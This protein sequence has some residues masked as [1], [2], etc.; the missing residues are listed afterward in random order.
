MASAYAK[1][2]F[3]VEE[4]RV[5]LLTNARK[6]VRHRHVHVAVHD[7]SSL[8]IARK[9]NALRVF[10]KRVRLLVQGVPLVFLKDMLD[11]SKMGGSVFL[12]LKKVV[13][14][15]HGSSKAKSIAPSVLQAVDA[16]QGNLIPNS[17]KTA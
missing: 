12:G 1:A 15:S 11:Y 6:A 10:E 17:A 8:D 2:A 7:I 13:V 3:G 4:P 5:G 16:Y 14:K 9:E